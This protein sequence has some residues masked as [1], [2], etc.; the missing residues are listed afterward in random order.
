MPDIGAASAPDMADWVLDLFSGCESLG[1]GTVGA[2]I[3]GATPFGDFHARY[4]WW[5]LS[6][7]F[8]PTTFVFKEKDDLA[9]SGPVWNPPGLQAFSDSNPP[10]PYCGDQPG[11]SGN[12]GPCQAH[13]Y[14]RTSDGRTVEAEGLVS[15][16]V[17]RPWSGLDDASFA[18]VMAIIGPGWDLHGCFVA[19]AEHALNGAHCL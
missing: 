3:D 4:A 2:R 11:P 10:S 19:K 8:C 12:S 6:A 16:V 15:G 5:S 7:A 13:L 18:G 9:V 1:P 14:F 17:S